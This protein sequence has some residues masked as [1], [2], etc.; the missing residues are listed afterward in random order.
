MSIKSSTRI[1]APEWTAQIAST[2]TGKRKNS[3]IYWNV[4]HVFKI[5]TMYYL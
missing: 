1:I 3:T 2:V 5:P 4:N